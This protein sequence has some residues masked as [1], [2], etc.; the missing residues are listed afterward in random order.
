M[1]NCIE[2]IEQRL[3]EKMCELNPGC[4]I[5]EVVEFQHKS[6]ILESSMWEILN[7]PV[8]GKY[9]TG[10]K[11][12]KFT[13]TMLPNYCPYCGEKIE[14]LKEQEDEPENEES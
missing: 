4:E 11:T 5:I 8:L 10:N 12:K 1:C 6:W 9:R 3:T 13:I 7:N 2:R 14:R